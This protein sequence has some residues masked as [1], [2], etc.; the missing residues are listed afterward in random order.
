MRNRFTTRA[1]GGIKLSNTVLSGFAAPFTITAGGTAQSPAIFD[2]QGDVIDLGVYLTAD[3][4]SDTG[5]NIWRTAAGTFPEWSDGYHAGWYKYDTA[6]NAGGG[7]D[8]IRWQV[9]QGLYFDSIAMNDGIKLIPFQSDAAT[10]TTQ[11]QA[12]WGRSRQPGY[13]FLQCRQSI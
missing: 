5:G 9:E 4:W 7:S 13:S 2:G 8:Y 12:K 11:G 3:D 6:G 10:L 1:I